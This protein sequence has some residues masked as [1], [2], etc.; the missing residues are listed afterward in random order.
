MKAKILSL[1][2]TAV[3]ALTLVPGTVLAE[4]AAPGN[5]DATAIPAEEPEPGD[6]GDT[7]AD[8]P[9]DAEEETE[10]APWVTVT[11]KLDNVNHQ[12]YIN[13]SNDG[14]FHPDSPLTR[15]EAAQII[16]S[17]IT[18]ATEADVISDTA[19]SDVPD[20]AWYAPAVNALAS[21]GVM[22]GNG[23]KF[24]PASKITRA[25]FVT[26][27]SRFD[28]L[29]ESDKSFK[30]VSKD[31][32]GYRQVVSAAE[33]GWVNGY[34]DGTFLPNKTL[35]R[36]E[37]VTIINRVLQ[38]YPDYDSISNGSAVRIFPDLSGS[39]WAY[40]QIMEASQSHEYT[41][42]GYSENWSNVRKEKSALKAGYH[43]IG[44][45]L[46][47]VEA[48]G[49][50]AAGKTVEGH[51]FDAGGKYT[52]GNA[53]L[54]SLMRAETRKFARDGMTRDQ[55]LKAAF[56]HMADMKQFQYQKMGLI[57][58]G[59]TGWAEGRAVPMYQNRKG[60]CYSYAS[61][62][63]FLLKNV[64]YD[65]EIVSGYVGTKHSDHGWVQLMKNGVPY[66]Y[67]PELTMS[68]RKRGDYNTYLFGVTYN[69]PMK[70][71]YLK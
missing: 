49:Y 62:F 39:H 12:K 32:W 27:L 71:Y 63:Y 15:A 57:P 36:A 6:P 25:E 45:V 60:N 54:D 59:S 42:Y 4:E 19:F 52:T 17:L 47:Y 41:R 55:L 56:E 64:G 38:R 23:G 40:T 10:P 51:W 43:L 68:A 69:N 24:R 61:A 66:V 46:Y 29:S 44:G 26:I 65:P 3:L 7:A 14:L 11:V 67:D 58:A 8:E 1:V 53:T 33:K 31:F 18:G 21:Y 22:G 30:D 70:R 34:N 9:G 28:E 13:G 37:A 50:Y 48:S 16:Y 2:L 35:T 5:L 20:N